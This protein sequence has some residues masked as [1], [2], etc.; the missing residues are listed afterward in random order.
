MDYYSE[1]MDS[2][3]PSC[4]ILEAPI[5]AIVSYP[6]LAEA[7]DNSD[8]PGIRDWVQ[9]IESERS[10]SRSRNSERQNNFPKSARIVSRWSGTLSQ[11]KIAPIREH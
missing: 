11:T 2:T 5:L 8:R 1:L 7:R 10:C 4:K 6:T 9:Q 3:C